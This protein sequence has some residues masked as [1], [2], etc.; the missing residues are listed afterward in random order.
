MVNIASTLVESAR[1]VPERTA[2]RLGPQEWSYARLD[3]ASARLAGLLRQWGV[4]VGDR[5]VLIMPNVP[6]FACLYY[7]VLRA[8]AVTVPLNPLL[9][10]REIA[11]HVTDCSAAVVLTGPMTADAAARAVA[12]LD[13]VRLVTVDE[14]FAGLLADADPL[15]E[16]AERA[17]DDLAVLLYTSGTTGSPKG[18]MLSHANI[19]GN[20]EVF[21][22]LIDATEDDVFFGGLPFFHSFGQTCALGTAVAVGAQV[23]LLPRFDP[24]RAL[25]VVQRDRVTVFEG[26]PTM[27][28]AI[29]HAPGRERYD[30]SSLRIAV[31]GGSALP[32]EVLHGFESAFGVALLEGYGLSETSP[33]VAF[34][35]TDLERVPGSVGLPVDGVRTRVVGPDLADVA[36]G[37]VGEL[38]VSGP[39]VMLGYW[40]RP[41]A[42]A[43]VM[44]GEWFRTGDLV[45][46]DETGRIHVVDRSKDVIIRGG[47]NVYPREVEEVL[48]E[49]PAVAEAAVVGVPD[50][51]WGEEVAAVVVPRPGATAKPEELV[52]WVRE[53]VA[54]YKYPRR[55]AL[56]EALPK[57]PTGKIL[58]RSIDRSPLVAEQP[59]SPVRQDEAHG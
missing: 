3:D 22:R 55:V 52:E 16:V 17:G 29:L 50:E 44:A 23:T 51:R 56:A 21:R 1:R 38:L 40:G 54:A 7:G 25:E 37:E 28:T 26:V 34:N 14:E 35:R 24:A 12:D 48:Y 2:V 41:E 27:Y 18:A 36:P 10:Q 47:Y 42:T 9:K 53:R 11:F 45:R 20:I 59:D 8:G 39:N 49:H 32:V 33:V 46:Q 19:G 30:A 43:G 4:G 5:V 13:G 6:E 58:K 31:S 15:A 57:G